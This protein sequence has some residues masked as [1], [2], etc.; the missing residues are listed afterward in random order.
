[1]V[2]KKNVKNVRFWGKI[3]TSGSDYYI[4]EGAAEG[5]DEFP[6][7]PADTEAKGTGINTLYYWA[8][9][10]L[11]GDWSELPVVTPQQ[12]RVSRKIKKILSGDLNAKVVSNP[13]FFGKEA[14][15]VM[16]GLCSS[17]VRFFE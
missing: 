14:H 12:M 5:G 6:D 8:T 11:S 3:L 17:S 7:M 10:Q 4:A 15:L 9:T 2:V 13:F 16:L 1:M